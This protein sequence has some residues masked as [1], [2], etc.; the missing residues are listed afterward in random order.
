[1]KGADVITSDPGRLQALTELWR[2]GGSDVW[3]TLRGSSMLPAFG[4]GARLRI[5]CRRH[6]IRPG[7]VVA[8]QRADALVVHRVVDIQDAGSASERLVTCQGDANLNPDTPIPLE[9]VL[10]VVTAARPA[11][12]RHRVA[13]YLRRAADWSRRAIQPLA[14]GATRERPVG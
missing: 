13:R 8:Y 7:H 10:G 4:P 2:S 11:P 14:T 9:A 5:S 12:W 6:G 3:I 1:V